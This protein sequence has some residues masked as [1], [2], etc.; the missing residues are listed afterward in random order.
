[1]TDAAVQSLK[2]LRS[3]ASFQ[4]YVVPLLAGVIYVYATEVERK[5]WH[6]L[7]AGLLLWTAEFL[8]EILNALLLH[9]SQFAPAWCTPGNTAYLIMTGLNI[10]I[11]SM[12]AVAGLVLIKLLPQDREIKILNLPNRLVIPA[13]LGLFCVGVEVILNQWGALVW[14]YSWWRWPNI[15]LIIVGYCAPFYG[16]TWF[17][18]RFSLRAKAACLVGA[19]ALV[20]SAWL[21][22][23]VGLKWI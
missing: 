12:F 14:A 15:Y 18:D 11:A 8:W 13:L 9:F 1:M 5:N 17:Y 21:V 20:I 16:V 3:T 23:A 6:G 22:F 7:L 2:I 19:L 4:W 10:E